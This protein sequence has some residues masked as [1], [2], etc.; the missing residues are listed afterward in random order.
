MYFLLQV[1]EGGDAVGIAKPIYPS[2]RWVQSWKWS[3]QLSHRGGTRQCSESACLCPRCHWLA[4]LWT[5]KSRHLSPDAIRRGATS[6]SNKLQMVQ[7]TWFTP[8]SIVSIEGGGIMNKTSAKEYLG[9]R[10]YKDISSSKC[11][12]CNEYHNYICSLAGVRY[13]LEQSKNT[14]HVFH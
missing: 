2:E 13:R 1:W 11:N 3:R 4:C 8:P 10:L 12:S 7:M 6:R 9:A 5:C 14:P